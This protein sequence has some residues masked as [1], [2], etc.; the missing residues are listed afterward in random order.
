MADGRGREL[1]APPGKSAD[2]VAQPGSL[3]GGW[4]SFGE[5]T[6][7]RERSKRRLVVGLVIVLLLALI[8]GWASSPS[9]EAPRQVESSP[10]GNYYDTG[11]TV[12]EDEC[13]A[14]NG[15]IVGDACYVP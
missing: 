15:T 11:E 7:R 8:R 10:P 9:A 5:T 1:P 6:P 14:E 13:L 4:P 3:P 2:H 12:T